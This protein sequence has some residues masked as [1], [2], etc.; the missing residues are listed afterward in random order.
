M[1]DGILVPIGGS[2]LEFGPRPDLK[3]DKRVGERHRLTNATMSDTIGS[4]ITNTRNFLRGFSSFKARARKG[5]AVRVQDKEGE[6]L[7]TAA[8]SR[9][10]LLGA[11]KGKIAFH[12]DLTK[13]TLPNESWKPSL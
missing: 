2:C 13:P 1:G 12:G 9:K 3:R 6:F 10:S 8:A 11:A 7:F 4:M 5:E